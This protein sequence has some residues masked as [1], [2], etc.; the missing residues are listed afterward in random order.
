[1]PNGKGTELQFLSA[2]AYAC[3]LQS[4][5]AISS[6]FSA[7][8][9]FSLTGVKRVRRARGSPATNRPWTEAERRVVLD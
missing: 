1:V 4:N 2:R 7:T 3:T 5:G 8:S 6:A 9:P